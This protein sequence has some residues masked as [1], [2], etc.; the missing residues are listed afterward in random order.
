MPSICFT[1]SPLNLHT[2]ESADSQESPLDP[3]EGEGEFEDEPPQH[4]AELESPEVMPEEDDEDEE[5]EDE[6]GTEEASTPRGASRQPGGAAKSEGYKGSPPPPMASQARQPKMT[7][8]VHLPYH[9]PPQ[10]P[11]SLGRGSVASP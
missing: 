8:R 3:M 7:R 2:S 10:G 1:S 6:E 5:D 9:R 4:E 11:A